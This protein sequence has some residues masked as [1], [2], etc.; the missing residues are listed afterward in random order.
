[1]RRRARLALAATALL[2]A[3]MPAPAAE[4]LPR[5]GLLSPGLDP[6]GGGSRR[7][8]EGLRELGHV[9]G[10]TAVIDYH[11]TGADA[12]TY[13]PLAAAALAAGPSVIVASGARCLAAL[14]LTK[15]V[16][17]VCAT[18]DDP[19][20]R[21]LVASYARP[22][23]NLTGIQLLTPELIHKRFQL[24]KEALPGA[25]RIAVLWL[26]GQQV[27][28]REAHHDAGLL[29]LAIEPHLV[30]DP[31]RD[32]EPA[33]R[34]ATER[35]IAAVVT[36]QEAL[37][38][39]H[40]KAIADLGLRYR[41]P[42]IAGESEFAADGGLMQFGPDVFENWYRA[43]SYVDRI[44][45]GASAGDQPIEQPTKIVLAVNLKTAK[46]L[47]LSLPPSLLARADEVIE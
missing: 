24:V 1:M 17:I 4:K 34:G 3:A 21:G 46:A 28:M 45:K 10:R 13:A 23:G 8:L 30:T 44:L 33:F 25:R 11:F 7:F 29:D 14:E 40:S 16:P 26:P 22:G 31:A 12:A 42:T 18:L 38:R 2:A 9:D 19:V 47:G 6:M 39:L 32:L 15:R 43:A 20:N 37:F 36:T 35:G 41:L 5:I 27:L